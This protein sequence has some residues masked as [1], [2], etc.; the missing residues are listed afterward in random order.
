VLG[1]ARVKCIDILKHL[2][3]K[4]GIIT[5]YDLNQYLLDMQSPFDLQQPID[6]LFTRLLKCRTFAATKD[7]ISEATM[8][9]AGLTI[10]ENTASFTTAISEWLK[11][12]E[13][14]KTFVNFQTHFKTE[15]DER[16]RLTTTR[17]A[18]YH[19]EVQVQRPMPA[20]SNKT[21]NGWYYC[22]SHGVT[23]NSEHTSATCNRQ[24]TGHCKEATMGNMLG[25]CNTVQRRLG[26][27]PVFV[28]PARTT[29]AAPTAAP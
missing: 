5:E 7:P 28:R 18:G 11:I 2:D 23:R 6:K 27:T 8:I 1:Y 20:N 13:A 29:Q 17:G 3:A 4:Y 14:T 26:E 21:E 19:Q 10:L 22:W 24:A 12:T 15:D 16:R 9:R 25:G